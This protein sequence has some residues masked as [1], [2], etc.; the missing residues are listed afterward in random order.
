[1]RKLLLSVVLILCLLPIVHAADEDENWATGQVGKLRFVYPKTWIGTTIEY[2]GLIGLANTEEALNT[3]FDGGDPTPGQAGIAIFNENYLLE[4]FELEDASLEEIAQVLGEDT[5]DYTFTPGS[6]IEIEDKPAFQITGE[7]AAGSAATLLV[8]DTGNGTAGIALIAAASQIREYELIF[9]EIASSLEYLSEVG[10][11]AD[12]ALT[13]TYVSLHPARLT[14]QMPEGA[15]V[16]EEEGAV[17]MANSENALMLNDMES[18]DLI[19]MFFSS[20]VFAEEFDT[21]PKMTAEQMMTTF[22]DLLVDDPSTLGETIEVALGE[23]TI[24]QTTVSVPDEGTEGVLLTLETEN[25]AAA[26]LA[27]TPMGEFESFQPLV[28]KILETLDYLK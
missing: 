13:R 26:V 5:D 23:R 17:L 7:N 15:L 16:F 27:A 22:R 12:A 28:Y 10:F 6:E 2:E 19:I 21:T 4:E 24:Y 18:G 3:L 8:V 9:Q 14:F 25:G 1:M 20:D 11:D